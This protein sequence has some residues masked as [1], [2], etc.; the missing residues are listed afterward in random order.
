MA[1]VGLF[2]IF[3]GGA[4]GSAGAFG[5]TARWAGLSAATISRETK[6]GLGGAGLRGAGQPKISAAS[7]PPC[8]IAATAQP[9]HSGHVPSS[10]QGGLADGSAKGA[11]SIASVSVDVMALRIGGW[12]EN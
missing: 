10:R 9:S 3:T 4:V 12:K 1:G 6:A 2:A 11:I 5:R 8:S 7:K